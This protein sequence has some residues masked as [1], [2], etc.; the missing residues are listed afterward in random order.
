MK[1]HEKSKDRLREQQKRPQK[2]EE[3]RRKQQDKGEEKLDEQRR[4]GKNWRDQGNSRRGLK[5]M[6]RN[7]K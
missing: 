2:E 7:R 5:R 6:S 1:Q 4:L 3:R